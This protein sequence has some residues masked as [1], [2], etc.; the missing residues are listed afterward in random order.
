[1]LLVFAM[2]AAVA[3]TLY[4][5]LPRLVFE[6]QRIQEQELIDRGEEYQRAIQL[7]V[8]KN[9]KYPASLDDLEQGGAGIRFL[10]R[11]YT[12]P[13]T[14]E[15]EWRVIHI[16]AGGFYTDS[17]IHKPQGEQEKE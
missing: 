14:G 6:S 15:D 10:R 5:E 16:D 11:R 3:I 2:A 12:D 17:L 1:M 7:Y 8:R 13:M 9:K 4:S